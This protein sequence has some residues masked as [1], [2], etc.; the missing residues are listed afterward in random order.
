VALNNS[1]VMIIGFFLWLPTFGTQQTQEYNIMN[2]TCT[3][4]NA[5]CSF[6]RYTLQ[7]LFCDHSAWNLQKRWSRQELGYYNM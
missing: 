1:I 2:L 6:R 7:K 4:K 5:D 3:Q